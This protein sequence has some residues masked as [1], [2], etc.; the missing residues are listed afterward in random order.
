[1]FPLLKERKETKFFY[2]IRIQI[3]G[4]LEKAVGTGLGTRETGLLRC[5]TFCLLIHVLAA[6]VY[7]CGEN[8]LGYTLIESSGYA[9][10]NHHHAQC[11]Q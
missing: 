1:M 2:A 4:Y 9:I 8:V 10:P 11:R 3:S 6:K 7:S 5:V